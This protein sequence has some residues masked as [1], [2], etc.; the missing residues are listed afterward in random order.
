MIETIQFP[1]TGFLKI[2]L[3]DD[4]MVPI[5][6]EI[7]EIKENFDISTK[8]NSFLVGNI[9]KEY[10]LTK[11]HNYINKLMEQ[12]VRQYNQSFDYLK[13]QSYLSDNLPLWVSN[14]WVNFQEKY[15]FNPVHDHSGV[16]SFVI[17]V[18]LPFNI[19]DEIENSPGA[20]SKSPLAGH[21]CFYYTDALGNIREYDIP[22]DESF[23]NCMLLFPS[24]MKH[25]VHPFYSSDQHRVSVS[26]NI[27]FQ[28]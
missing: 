3:T 1:N 8:A 17:W 13:T 12:Y 15:E 9:K 21:F 27:V 4:Q 22:A 24:H 25:S 6:Q 11:C 16:F 23:E 26:G 5:I 18:T 28:I 19:K 20:K 7:N 10:K 14:V 2:E